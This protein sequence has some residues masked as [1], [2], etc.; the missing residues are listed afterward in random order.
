MYW[1][2]VLGLLIPSEAMIVPLYLLMDSLWSP[3]TP[4]LYD[5]EFIVFVG[6]QRIEKAS[7]SGRSEV[8]VLV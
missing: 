1:L 6:V 5:V 3:E 7:E 4:N 8:Y 2:I